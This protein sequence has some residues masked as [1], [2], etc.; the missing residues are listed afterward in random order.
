MADLEG[1]QRQFLRK[2]SLAVENM[3]CAACSAAVESALRQHSAVVAARASYLHHSVEA[4]YDGRSIDSTS[5][6]RL[7]HDAGFPSKVIKDELMERSTQFARFRIGGM[8]C[9]GC[10]GAVESALVATPGV[11]HASVSL[12]LQEARVEFDSELTNEV[13]TCFFTWL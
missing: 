9:I 3:H 6:L 8:T 10:S 13:S 1:E 5:L 11:L 2:T 7:L 4:T 12:T